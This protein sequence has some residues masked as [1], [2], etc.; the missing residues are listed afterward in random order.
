MAKKDFLKETYEFVC[1]CNKDG[2]VVNVHKPK[3]M[4][5]LPLELI[6]HC[7]SHG[8]HCEFCSKSSWFSGNPDYG[9]FDALLTYH[10]HGKTVD[11]YVTAILVRPFTE[12]AYNAYG[13]IIEKRL[14]ANFSKRLRDIFDSRVYDEELAQ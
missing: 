14:G 7:F 6:E 5:D 12:D 10:Q 1:S 2:I 13:D 9:S 4:R 11:C 8:H 3:T